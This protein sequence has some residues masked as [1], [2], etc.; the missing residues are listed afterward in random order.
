TGFI[1]TNKSC[2][3]QTVQA[4]VTDFNAGEL[5][6]P[7]G[8]PDALDNLVHAHQ[9]DV[10]DSA[11]WGAIDAAEIERGADEGRPRNKFTAIAEMLAAAATAPPAPRRGLL[12][13]LRG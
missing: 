7:V 10:V 11:G 8:K 12:A 3:L 1:G 9:P 5:T 13:R 6:D 4:L 2:S